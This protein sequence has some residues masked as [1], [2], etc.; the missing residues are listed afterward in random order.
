[1]RY[2][3][4]RHHSAGLREAGIP[5]GFRASTSG[6]REEALTVIIK[7]TGAVARSWLVWITLLPLLFS[8]ETLNTKHSINNSHSLLSPLGS[9]GPLQLMKL[10]RIKNTHKLSGQHSD[11]RTNPGKNWQ[12]AVAFQPRRRDFNQSGCNDTILHPFFKL[13]ASPLLEQE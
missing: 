8:A 11:S 10:Q 5:Q 6:G 3:R 13:P 12:W 1:M 2:K 7:G 9:V 4:P